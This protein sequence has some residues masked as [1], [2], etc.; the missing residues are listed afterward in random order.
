ML[1][2]IS[3]LFR[4]LELLLDYIRKSND[5]TSKV[6]DFH[7]PQTLSAAWRHAVL[8]LGLYVLL[9]ERHSPI[10]R[11]PQ[12][13]K[14]LMSHCLDIPEQPQNIERILSDCEETLKYCVKT[15]TQIKVKRVN[16]ARV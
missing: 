10:R 7:H 4:L 11:Q 2:R 3:R 9:G 13:L 15:G 12:T 16:K 6:L 14:E 5:R 8:V 1:P